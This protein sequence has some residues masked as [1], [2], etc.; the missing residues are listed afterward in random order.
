MRMT[1]GVPYR[2]WNIRPYPLAGHLAAE[3]GELGVGCSSREFGSVK[4]P[5]RIIRRHLSS[6]LSIKRFIV[7]TSRL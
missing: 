1:T 2:E 6:V 4:D 3:Y 7:V 5:A